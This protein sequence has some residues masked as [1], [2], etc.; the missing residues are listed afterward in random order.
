MR[1]RNVGRYTIC[2]CGPIVITSGSLSVTGVSGFAFTLENGISV[3]D[4]RR[5]TYNFQPA[6]VPEPMTLTLLA[7]GLLGLGAKLRSHT[8]DRSQQPQRST[9]DTNA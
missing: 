3:Y 9:K 2:S 6:E 8:R 4:F 1:V 5:V 7:T